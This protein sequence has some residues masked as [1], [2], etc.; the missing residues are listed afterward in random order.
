MEDKA[1]APGDDGFY[2]I[3]AEEHEHER[4]QQ[5][6]ELAKIADSLSPEERTERL[7][8]IDPGLTLTRKAIAQ[9]RQQ[10]D[11]EDPRRAPGDVHNHVI[12]I[13]SAPIV[14]EAKRALLDEVDPDRAISHAAVER[15]SREIPVL[16][17]DTAKRKLLID[18]MR[19]YESWISHYERFSLQRNDCSRL[20][21]LLEACA[22]GMFWEGTERKF[23]WRGDGE[24]MLDTAKVFVVR[25]DWAAAIGPNFDPADPF[26]LPAP[27]CAF[28]FRINDCTI[29]FAMRERANGAGIESTIS[30]E[31]VGGLWF[32][33]PLEHTNALEFYLEAQVRSI[34][35]ALEAKVAT[36]EV[37]RAPT[38]LNDKRARN[39]KPPLRDFHTV[40]LSKRHRAARPETPASPSGRR[41]PRLHFRRGHWRHYETTKTWIEWMLVGDPDLGFIDKHYRI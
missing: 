28:E 5:L 23:M 9:I 24:S 17:R 13:A 27:V 15:L 21:K 29:I 39:G 8:R 12:D 41:S 38:K 33:Y 31:G 4:M 1:T 19:K 32:S 35:I 20:H 10:R 14:A 16:E 7:H 6:V 3:F 40:D 36:H 34:C 2:P 18:S 25:H 22:E 11:A 26:K 37:T 30:Q